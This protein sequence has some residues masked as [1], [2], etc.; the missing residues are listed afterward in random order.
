VRF[1]DFEIHLLVEGGWQPDGGAIFGVV[2]KVLWERRQPADERNLIPSA[3]IGAVIR[4]GGRTI[5]CETGIGTKLDA[6]RARAY[7]LWEP[8]GLLSGL[9]SLGIRPEEV[10]LVLT[11]HLH[12]DHAGGFTRRRADGSYQVTFPNA[13]HYVQRSEWDFA[14]KPDPRSKAAY[15]E[16]DLLP[17][18]DAGLVE[19]IDGDAE[20]VS[21]ISVRKTG[22]HSP[23]HQL[24]IVRG[25]QGEFACVLCGDLI[26]LR[27]HL[28]LPWIPAADL[29]VLKTIEE[30][31]R[32]LDEASRNRWLLLLGHDVEH[33]AGY[34]DDAGEWFLHPELDAEAQEARKRWP[35][36]S[37]SATASAPRQAPPVEG[38]R[39]G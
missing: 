2:P 9:Q 32:L 24:V 36:A 26:G 22:G 33:P 29:D 5:V 17:V 31:T 1:G 39:R 4:S 12:W 23:G 14:L 34:V 19:L 15:L 8:E 25:G 7:G 11:T 13:K 28:R 6:K 35:Q 27:P 38:S 21:G 37:A 30:K 20:I 10:D 18:A 16:E 3:C